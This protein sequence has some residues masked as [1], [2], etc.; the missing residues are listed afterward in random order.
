MHR[1]L[2]ELWELMMDRETWCAAI[3]GVSKS[4]TQLSD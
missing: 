1:S 3:R 4:S 2:R